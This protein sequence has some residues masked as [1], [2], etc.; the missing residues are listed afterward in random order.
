M[1]EN[2]L[3]SVSYA[4]FLCGMDKSPASRT[5]T[6]NAQ[7]ALNLIRGGIAA[8][9][10]S[11][12]FAAGAAAF[13]IAS[14]ILPFVFSW[15]ATPL[16]LLASWASYKAARM[17]IMKSA[18]KELLGKGEQSEEVMEEI[19]DRLVEYDLLRATHWPR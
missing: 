16:C 18:W 19:Y 17:L 6:L 11:M 1:P 5:V 4:E 9:F 14:L 10:P 2:Q 7:A 8:P 15:L 12:F 3:K 13:L